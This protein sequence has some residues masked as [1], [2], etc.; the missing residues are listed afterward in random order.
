MTPFENGATTVPTQA[1]T[2]MNSPF[3]RDLAARL[4]KRA[5]AADAKPD[6]AIERIFRIALARPPSPGEAERFKAFF[7]R[8]QSLLAD[9]VKSTPAGLEASL[10]ETSL[11][12][13]CMNEF[14]YVD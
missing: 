12:L 7:S 3:V 9:N 14:I 10:A 2:M 1:L 11:A 6:A 13:L 5:L 8:Q 4:A